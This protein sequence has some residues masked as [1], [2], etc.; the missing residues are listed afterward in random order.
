MSTLEKTIHLL[1]TL[2]D[3]K[4]ET[5]YTFAQFLNSELTEKK[6]TASEK[7]QKGFE[8]IMSFAGTLPENFD[9]KQELDEAR[10][11]KYAR[12]I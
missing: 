5:I 10:E 7:R 6:T 9:Y 8:G 1:E 3:D 12:F 2:P 4:I 11:A